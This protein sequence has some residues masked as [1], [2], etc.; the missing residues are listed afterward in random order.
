MNRYNLIANESIF[1]DDNIRNI[2]AADKFGIKT[3]H[4]IAPKVWVWRE[5][6]VKKLKSYIDHILLLFPFE[7]KF[8]D[9]NSLSQRKSKLFANKQ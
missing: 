2:K 5:G 7:K 8:F 3:I 6:R 4:F 1:I 9:K